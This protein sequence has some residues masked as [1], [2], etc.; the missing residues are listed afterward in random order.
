MCSKGVGGVGRRQ[1]QT[2]CRTYEKPG[3]QAFSRSEG[4]GIQACSKSNNLITATCWSERN[5]NEF[6][7]GAAR[8]ASKC[9][10]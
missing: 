3:V 7:K 1:K 4:M 6:E 8:K 10:E 2:R 5:N 9:T